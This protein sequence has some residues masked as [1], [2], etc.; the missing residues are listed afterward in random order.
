MYQF[1][2]QG[3][4]VNSEFQR[5]TSGQGGAVSIQDGTYSVSSSI[6]S[7]NIALYDGGSIKALQSPLIKV[8]NCSFL[9]I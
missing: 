5:G 9:V 3:S 6:F 1:S 8:F 4:E 2:G 7:N